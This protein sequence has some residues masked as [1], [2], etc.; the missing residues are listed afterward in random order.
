MNEP[1]PAE[2]AVRSF[3]RET[4]HAV[5]LELTFTVTRHP[6]EPPLLEVE[7][8][9]NDTTLLLQNGGDLLQALKYFATA[10]SGLDVSQSDPVSISVRHEPLT[11]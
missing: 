2:V 5:R 11:C 7:F 9:G 8:S 6:G 3:L 1:S 4:I 10:V